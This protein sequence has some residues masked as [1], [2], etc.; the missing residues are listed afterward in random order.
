MKQIFII[1]LSLVTLTSC[2]KEAVRLSTNAN[3]IFWLSNAGADMPIWVKGNTASKIMILFIHGGPGDGS[4]G[5]TGFETDQLWKQYS[6]AYWDQRDA[7]A[8]AGNNNY[9]NLQ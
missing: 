2:K 4:Y 9:A 1:I 6:I 7:G 8:A 5:Y 3:D